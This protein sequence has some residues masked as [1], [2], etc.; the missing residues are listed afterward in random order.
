MKVRCNNMVY[1]IKYWVRTSVHEIPH[2]KELYTA[3]TILKILS[4]NEI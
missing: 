2:G 3:F 1:E 4:G